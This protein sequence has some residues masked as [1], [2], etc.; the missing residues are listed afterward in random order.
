[1]FPT[2][3]RALETKKRNRQSTSRSIERLPLQLC[4][5]PFPSSPNLGSI[6]VHRQTLCRIGQR[7]GGRVIVRVDI[8]LGDGLLVLVFGRELKRLELS[9]GV[10]EGGLGGRGDCSSEWGGHG[11]VVEGRWQSERMT[12]R[13]PSIHLNILSYSLK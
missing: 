10:P 9:D 4:I 8:G 12:I 5:R 11:M 6:E 7:D 3:L 13:K 2:F 1:M